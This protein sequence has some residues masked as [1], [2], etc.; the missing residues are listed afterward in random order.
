MKTNETVS[1]QA[2]DEPFD[3][4]DTSREVSHYQAGTAWR[5]SG[6]KIKHPSISGVKCNDE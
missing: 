1:G 3:T 5:N 6:S 4:T 2:Q